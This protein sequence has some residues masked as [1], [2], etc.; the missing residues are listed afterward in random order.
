MS[1]HKLNT[2]SHSGNAGTF[3]ALLV[4]RQYPPSLQ[5]KSS[6]MEPDSHTKSLAPQDYSSRELATNQN[7]LASDPRNMHRL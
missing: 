7:V 2:A 5:H 6:F 3:I 4:F 1:T